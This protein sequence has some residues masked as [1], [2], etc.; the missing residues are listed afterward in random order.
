MQ[1]LQVASEM[2]PIAKVGG[3]GDVIM[4]LTRELSWKGHS[5]LAV[6]PFYGLIDTEQLISEGRAEWFETEFDGIRQKASVSFFRSHGDIPLALLDTESGYFRKR[7]TIYGDGDSNASFLF[8]CRAITDWLLTT[9]RQP[10]ILHVHDWP[11]ALLPAIYG[12]AGRSKPPFKSVFTVHNFDYQGRCGWE[13]L[14]RIG[15]YPGDFLDP[16]ILKDPCHECMNLVKGGLLFADASTTV[17]PTYAREMITPEEGQ[18]LDGVLTHLGNRFSGILNGLDYAFWNPEI[19]PF[20]AK[21]YG[22]SQEEGQIQ[23]A[24]LENRERLFFN[25]GVP[26]IRDVP[27]ITSVTRLVMQKGIWLIRDLFAQAEALNFQCLLLGSVAEPDA[28]RAFVELDGFLR[29]KGRG[30]I[31]LMS[32]E[33]FAHRTY[34]ASDIFIAPSVFEPCGLTQ[35][36]ALKYGSIPVVRR[37]GGLADTIVDVEQSDSA[38]NGFCF[39]AVDSSQFTSAVA[40]ACHLFKDKEAWRLLMERG[41]KQ[42]FSW[43][44]PGTQYVE[45]Y[46]KL[47][48]C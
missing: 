45:L 5:V 20:L 22:L 41:M 12:I 10:D 44:H 36:I 38:S 29:S 19:D 39:D 15:I 4:G 46:H 14:N 23:A 40:R 33:A 37:T 30:A 28:E 13:E 34:A 43:N 7:R 31:F 32:D 11:T 17:S 48:Q 26:V 1:I 25:I 21:K 9:N 35:L 47:L 6:L 2:T 24:K 18:G 3:L 8:F 27:L 16:S 42:D